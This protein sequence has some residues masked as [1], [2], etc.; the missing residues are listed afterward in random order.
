MKQLLLMLA[1]LLISVEDAI[2][3]KM[4]DSYALNINNIYLPIN[5]SGV[6]AEV[7]VPPLGLGG[8]FG[9]HTFLFSGGFCLSGL[10]DGE[11]WANAVASSSLI[12]DYL[13]GIYP[14]ST[15][16][17]QIYRVRSDDQPFGLSWQ[18]WIDAVSLGADF[19][20]GNRDGL[21][22]PV[23]L[24]ANGKW[25]PDE[26]RPDLIGDEMLWCVY[27]DGV[28]AAQRYWQVPPQYIEI[29]QTVFAYSNISS[30]ENIIFIRYCIKY[31][32]TYPAYLD[33]VY[34]T[35][36]DDP[37]LGDGADD[38]VG[39]D[40]LLQGGFVYNSGP[41][42]IYGS[43]P[44]AFFEAAVGGPVVYIPGETFIDENGNG[45]YDPGETPLDTA[46][47]R[48]GPLLGV[49]EYPGAKN[50]TL[51]SGSNY[52]NG[53]PGL[54]DPQTKEQARYYMLGL[55]A[56]GLI[57]NPCTWPYGDVRGGIDCSEVNPFFWYSGDPV[58][59]Y[60][61]IN[62]VSG[63][64]RQLQ[65]IGPFK[66]EY[67]KTSEVFVAYSV[68]QST[69]ALTSV[70]KTKDIETIAQTLYNSN[71][72]TA[73]VTSV[74]EMRGDNVPEDFSLNQNYPNPFNPGTKIKFSIPHQSKVIIKVYDLLGKEVETLVNEEKPV[75]IYE[76]AWNAANLPSGVYFYQLKAAPVGGQVGSFI[77]T[78]KM[79][80]LK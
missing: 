15:W 52:Y 75:G 61:W 46:I 28:P 8:Q 68:G 49:T 43:N 27:C 40:T 31:V 56:S 63:D 39:C 22:T 41:D 33:S 38:L 3:Q 2:P 72:D 50:Q 30:L 45:I 53:N 32:N 20:D 23:D 13:P 57:L 65:N 64:Q 7:N 11:L 44:P 67:G 16:E 34:F 54:G 29:R 4:G 51:S 36:W 80:L 78:K 79:I 12:R 25:D 42:D 5:S 1:V 70:A 10:N 73:A 18:D 58:Q 26:D 60:G 21:Y 59:N 62:S 69:N 66:L 47:I 9:G 48:R 6:L 24:N 76:V 77:T 55:N 37:D 71:F 17:A 19:Y 74:R 14:I 35:I